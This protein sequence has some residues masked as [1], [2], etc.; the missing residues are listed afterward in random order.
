VNN[1]PGYFNGTGTIMRFADEDGSLID[2]YQATTQMTDESGT[3]YPATVNALLDKALGPEGYYAALVANIHTDT[4]ASQPSDA[5]VSEALSRGVPVVSAKQMLDWLDARNASAYQSIAWNG[6]ALSFT[7]TGGANGLRGMVPLTTSA[8]NLVSLT[9]N[10]SPVTTTPQTIKGMQYGFFTAQTGNYVATY[11]NVDTVPPVVSSTNPVN[12]AD[13]VATNA[14]VTVTFN[15]TMNASTITT[16]NLELRNGGTLVNRT[17]SYNAATNTATIAPTAAL[18]PGTTYTVTVKGAPTGVRDA[19]GNTMSADHQVGFTTVAGGGG[20]L[21]YN[22]IGGQV[23][24]GAQNH[25][26]GSRF[27]T[28]AGGLS[29]TSMVVYMTTVAANNSYQM[30]IYT[31]NAG[32]PGS[33]VASTATGTL[34][35]NAWNSL[36]VSATLSGNTAYWLMYNTNGDNNMRF[37][38]GTAN[39]GSWSSA[40]TP[41]GTWPANFGSAVR[42]VAK[43]S[44]Y[45]TSASGD[46]VPPAVTAT[47]PVNG[48]TNVAVNSSMT[49][50]FNETMDQSTITTANLE[51]RTGGG[52]LVNRTVSYNAGT[53]TATITPAAALAANASYTVTVKGAPTGVE[54]AAGNAMA[55]DHQ[56]SFTTASGGGGPTILGYNQIGAQTDEGDQ[57][58][59]NGS[60]FITAPGGQTVTSMSV[61]MKG[62]VSPSSYQMAIY[63]D[64]AGVPGALVASTGTGTLTANAW[65]TLP[66]SASLAGNT[67]YWLMYN[68]NGNNNLS[69]DAGTAN[70]GGWSSNSTPFGTWPTTFGPVVRHNYRFSIYASS[71]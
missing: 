44:I 3:A 21:G 57:N 59:M 47:V 17:V 63:T 30:G 53:H 6:S 48:A 60:R 64:N 40:S 23:D 38:N 66:V 65:N 52:T 1:R 54:D 11:S 69:F 49:V 58:Y 31:D 24:S 67:A 29:V 22:Q 61:Y 9:R 39:Q 28:G 14:T 20:I 7:V 41:F 27:V 10:G 26:N 25:M 35:P 37:D 8:G 34:T 32:F 68:T 16:A 2:V 33:L 51:L 13:G 71:S 15:E 5:I 62:V 19:A 45:A 4:V 18:A 50:T 55:S 43:F 36:P 42:T 12:G 56:F 70:H 46:T